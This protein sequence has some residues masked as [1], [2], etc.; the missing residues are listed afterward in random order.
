MEI[1][2]E[3]SAEE[4]TTQLE[5]SELLYI[6]SPGYSGADTIQVPVVTES[7]LLLRDLKSALSSAFN[8]TYAIV[9]H[10]CFFG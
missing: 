8:P 7:A 9:G 4:V 2:L 3:G 5:R 10:S 1:I 6:R